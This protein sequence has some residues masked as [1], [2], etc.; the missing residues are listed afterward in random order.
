[1]SLRHVICVVSLQ[2]NILKKVG[3]PKLW[4]VI[5]SHPDSFGFICPWVSFVVLTAMEKKPT[6]KKKSTSTSRSWN[7][8]PVTSDKPPNTW[9]AVFVGIIYPPESSSRE[10]CWLWGLWIIL[11]NRHIV[12][13]KTHCYFELNVFKHHKKNSIH[14]NCT[15]VIWTNKFKT[16][17]ID[18]GRCSLW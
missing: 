17:A 5:S 18:L 16:Y 1:M 7:N 13:R 3:S 9:S 14:L 2:L 6:F 8:V 10:N 4:K 12:S 15:G 11:R